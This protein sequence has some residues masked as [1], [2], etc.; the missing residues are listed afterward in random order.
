MSLVDVGWVYT[1]IQSA[2]TF[3][4]I[5][6][7]FF[8]TKVLTISSEARSTR[9]RI[10]SVTDELQLA[11]KNAEGLQAKIDEY[12]AKWAGEDVEDFLGRRLVDVP[13]GSQP[14]SMD[15]I[16]DDYQKEEGNLN[17]FEDERL[18]SSYAGFVE[19]WS[20]EARS[21]ATSPLARAAASALGFAQVSNRPFLRKPEVDALNELVA[22]RKPLLAKIEL[23][24]IRKNELENQVKALAYPRYT[25][26][27]FSVLVYFGAVGVVLPLL[28]LTALD[29]LTPLVV[30]TF[31]LLFVSGFAAVVVYLMLEVVSATRAKSEAPST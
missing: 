7:A 10:K 11:Q 4:A 27:G 8:T 31:L 28:A 26:L 23:D 29:S 14:P 24:T 13:A 5:V 1:L 3:V 25:V 19:R 18:K 2:A 21:A 9:N 15:Q 30:D 16:R 22:E 20:Q 6:G 17:A 12:L